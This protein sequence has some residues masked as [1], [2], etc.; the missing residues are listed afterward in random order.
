VEKIKLQSRKRF[1]F[2]DE[3]A[4]FRHSLEQERPDLRDFFWLLLLTGARRGNVQAM[5]WREINTDLQIWMIPPHKHKN[6]EEHIIALTDPCLAIL[7]RQRLAAHPESRYVF[8]SRSK[9]GHLVEPK[10]AWQRIIKR[11]DLTDLRIHDL[12]RTLGSY[13]AIKGHSLPMI[14]Q[15]L[16]HKDAR[17]TQVYARLY[18][19]PVRKAV[20]GA[21]GAM[22]GRSI[23]QHIDDSPNKP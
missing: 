5:E 10:R 8:P 2:P 15:A 19:D 12:R 20:E 21:T 14:G 11:A 18:L 16:G 13:M 7:A 23:N 17:S 22:L 9:T 4:R 1:L 3:L 6:G